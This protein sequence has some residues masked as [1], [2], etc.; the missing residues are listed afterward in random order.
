MQIVDAAA[1]L[2]KIEGVA[3]KLFGRDA[4]GKRPI[5]NI[6]PVEASEPCSD[7]CTWKFVFQV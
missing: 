2:E 1:H 3:G 4:R 6:A 7:G 5:V